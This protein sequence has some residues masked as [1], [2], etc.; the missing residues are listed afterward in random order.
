MHE[1]Y[2]N[3][4]IISQ[5]MNYITVRELYHNARIISQCT[6]YITMHKLYHYARIISQCTNYITMHGFV[7]VKFF[8]LFLATIRLAW[9]NLL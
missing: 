3:A 6:N 9:K 2:R 8:F 7:K 1:L 4:R 5:C